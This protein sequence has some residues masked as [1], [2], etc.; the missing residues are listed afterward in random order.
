MSVF[1]HVVVGANNLE[2][3]RDF[4][5][6]VLGALCLKRLF[7]DESRSALGTDAPALLVTNPLDCKPATRANGGT[8]GLAASVRKAVDNFHAE[9]LANG[10]TCDGAPGRRDSSS[11]AYGAYIRDPD[12]NKFYAYC[13]AEE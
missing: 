3:S 2:N 9:V 8:V 12:G 4:Y 6:K 5:G 1:T 11:T 7:D 10:G 13:F